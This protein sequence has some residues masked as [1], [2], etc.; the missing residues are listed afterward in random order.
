MHHEQ[1]SELLEEQ[2]RALPP[3]PVPPDLEARLIAAV[4]AVGTNSHPRG[5][6]RLAWDAPNRERRRRLAVTAVL[7]GLAAACLLVFLV[8]TAR[9]PKTIAPVVVITGGADTVRD[10]VSAPDSDT[11]IAPQREARRV[12]GAS[13][14]S[15]FVWP[16]EGPI[17]ATI[18]R[19]I[20]PD[21]LN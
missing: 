14:S 13:E 18:V 12:L 4:P 1:D 20:P 3:L 15:A 7:S 2:L 11:K 19:R 21:L 8:W 6:H 10:T 16:V 5:G 17:P 9:R